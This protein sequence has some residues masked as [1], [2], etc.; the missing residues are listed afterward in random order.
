M[1][2]RKRE[3]SRTA[4]GPWPHRL[5]WTLA[6]AAFLL[7]CVGATVTTY[8]AGMAVPDWPTTEGYWFYPLPK[9][10]GADWDVFLEH[11]HRM[12]G[13][14]VGLVTIALAVAL[15]RL[16]P[17][18]GVRWLGVAAL[19]GVV[20]QGVLGGLRVLANAMPLAKVH[21]CTGPLFFALSAALVALT[22]PRWHQSGPPKK[23]PAARR[24]RGLA[25]A[26]T[27][28]LYLE[29]VLGAQLRHVSPVDA[30][31]W[32]LL[33]VWLKLILAG[34]ILATVV[35][36]L[37]DV[38]RRAGDEPMLVR[39]AGLLVGLC[40]VQLVLG[41][42]TWVTNYSWPLWFKTYVW[43]LSYTVVAEGGLQAV[44][45]TAHTAVGSLSLIAALSLVLWSR[46]R[47]WQ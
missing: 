8:S 33:W 39:R 15:W 23:L 35:W 5:A 2:R 42:A 6:C 17:R 43:T 14:L 16:D 28:A 44:T 30:P 9:W 40:S 32:F 3:T 25:L 1:K 46:R 29:V 20:F 13:Q 4:A 45:T 37:I 10:L 31:G 18:K 24:L 11:G 26:A 27:V 19:A 38:R 34:L 41:A 22:S 21:G 7:L 36:L 47:L 12:L